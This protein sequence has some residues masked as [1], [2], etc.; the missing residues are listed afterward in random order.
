M[1]TPGQCNHSMTNL[2]AIFNIEVDENLSMNLST[3]PIYADRKRTRIKLAKEPEKTKIELL[4]KNVC[5][6]L[7]QENNYM[8][9]WN[10]QSYQKVVS[11]KYR[12]IGTVY[13][14]LKFTRRGKIFADYYNH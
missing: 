6:Y 14:L 10:R 11:Q 2:G 12:I 5:S 3:I 4:L 8:R 9:E 13:R 7:N 1:D